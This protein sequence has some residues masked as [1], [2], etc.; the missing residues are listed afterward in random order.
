MDCDYCSESFDDEKSYIKHLKQQHKDDLKR[1]DRRK[2]EDFE[3]QKLLNLN[4]SWGVI[5]LVAIIIVS[6]GVV[7]VIVFGGSNPEFTGDGSNL[8]VGSD[9][10][11]GTIEVIIEGERIDFSQP[12]YQLQSDP[13][14]F[15]AGD[16]RQWH[17]HAENVP[18]K[19]AMQTVDI[20]IHNKT[21]ITHS[22]NTYTEQNYNISIASNGRPIDPTN[23][24][25]KQRDNIQITIKQ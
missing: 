16:G 6:F 15:E 20:N 23:Y 9:H 13:F 8:V 5:A 7:A 21:A 2:I 3:E 10:Y 4:I 24:I 22:G 25:L 1:I 18:L 11:H 14:H 19:F 17:A 12:R